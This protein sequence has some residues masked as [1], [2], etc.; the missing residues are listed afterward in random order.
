MIFVILA[1]PLQKIRK[2]E[3]YLKFEFAYEA[4]KATEAYLKRTILILRNDRNGKIY[5]TSIED[6][7]V[8]ASINNNGDLTIVN[9]F[10]LRFYPREERR[11]VIVEEPVVIYL[12]ECE[13][14]STH[15]NNNT[16]CQWCWANG[17]RY[18]NDP[19][20]V[21]VRFPRVERRS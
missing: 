10:K 16:V 2:D 18:W 11:K 1:H 6:W 7:Y 20:I 8:F 17:R 4:A 14:D 21:N 15:E 19:E 9:L 13:C 12:T 5:D 3:C